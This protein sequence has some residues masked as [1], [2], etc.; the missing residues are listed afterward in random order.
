MSDTELLV[1]FEAASVASF[2]HVDHL[3]VAW[4]YLE[5]RSLPETLVAMSAGLRRLSPPKKPRR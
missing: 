3:R 5:Q 2:H 1:Q 4:I